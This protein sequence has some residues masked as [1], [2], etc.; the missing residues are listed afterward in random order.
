MVHGQ[1]CETIA[2]LTGC[3]ITTLDMAQMNSWALHHLVVNLVVFFHSVKNH[4]FSDDGTLKE[5]P[6]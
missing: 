4:E 5:E 3:A 2:K 6:K 1:I